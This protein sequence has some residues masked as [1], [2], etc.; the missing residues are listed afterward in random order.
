M[1]FEKVTNSKMAQLTGCFWFPMG[2]TSTFLVDLCQLYQIAW[3]SEKGKALR[4]ETNL[5]NNIGTKHERYADGSW[6]I[7]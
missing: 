6:W 5:K 2:N 3:D 7:L 4:L 1:R